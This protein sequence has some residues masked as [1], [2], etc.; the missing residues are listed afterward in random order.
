MEDRYYN[1]KID[2]F[3]VGFEYWLKSKEPTSTKRVPIVIN[4]FSDVQDAARHFAFD[5]IAVKY[6][7][8]EDIESFGFVNDYTHAKVEGDFIGFSICENYHLSYCPW[9]YGNDE[10]R[11]LLKTSDVEPSIFKYTSFNENQKLK[12]FKS[13]SKFMDDSECVFNGVIKNKSELKKLL[14]Q[15]NIINE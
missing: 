14:I 9:S 10:Y 2:E 5:D 15:L 8:K 11:E 4:N 1:P 13:N 3:H 7:S 6:L 12:I